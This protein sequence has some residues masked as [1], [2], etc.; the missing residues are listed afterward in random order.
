MYIVISVAQPET[1]EKFFVEEHKNKGYTKFQ[2]Q[3]K[4]FMK[5]QQRFPIYFYHKDCQKI[6]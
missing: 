4:F 3:L 2:L 6:F 1:L 5:H